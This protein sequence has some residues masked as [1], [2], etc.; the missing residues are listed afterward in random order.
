[1]LIQYRSLSSTQS[2]TKYY[3]VHVL[4]F[5]MCCISLGHQNSHTSSPARRII[6]EHK[7]QFIPQLPLR[8]NDLLCK[9]QGKLERF[10]MPISYSLALPMIGGC[11]TFCKIQPLECTC[12]SSFFAFTRDCMPYR[13]FSEDCKYTLVLM[14]HVSVP[15]ANFLIPQDT[16]SISR[17]KLYIYVYLQATSSRLLL[18]LN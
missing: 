11:I 3:V 15:S 12:P 7:H 17:Y 6:E 18:S 13:L 10:L 4:L 9:I 16:T 5:T 8:H 14:K 2:K 1:M